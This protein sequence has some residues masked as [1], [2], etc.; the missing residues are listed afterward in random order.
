MKH[1]L[2]PTTDAREWK[3]R[4]SLL[5]DSSANGTARRKVASD[6]RVYYVQFKPLDQNRRR[7]RPSMPR[8]H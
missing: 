2:S 8:N 5:W 4:G 3:A 7:R 1:G 6:G